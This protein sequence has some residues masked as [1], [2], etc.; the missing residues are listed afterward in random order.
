LYYSNQK[1]LELAEQQ[2]AEKL[3]KTEYPERDPNKYPQL[4]FIKEINQTNR[5]ET[6]FSTNSTRALTHSYAK[7]WV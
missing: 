3:N 6:D 2:T 1:S 7:Q 4:I 5:T